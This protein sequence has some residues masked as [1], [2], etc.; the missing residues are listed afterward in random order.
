M[1]TGHWIERRFRGLEPEVHVPVNLGKNS[2]WS[3]WHHDHIANA[4]ALCQSV[5]G[6]PQTSY[7]CITG[8]VGSKRGILVNSEERLER[9]TEDF[10]GTY[11]NRLE[12]CDT[13]VN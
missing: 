11:S 1:S 5:T 10:D 4:I 9:D 7:C 6:A 12:C 2:Q 8:S 3:R 13:V